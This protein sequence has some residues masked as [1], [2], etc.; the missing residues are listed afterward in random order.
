MTRGALP[1][2]GLYAITDSSLH[3]GAALERAVAL[4]IDGGAAIIQY[5]D[6]T[7]DQDRRHAEATRLLHLCRR[8]G[9]PLIVND[10][11]ELAL[12]IGA[13][14]V[15]VGRE[16]AAPGAT[17]A[18]VGSRLI[19]GVSCYDDP[20]C[21]VQAQDLGADYVAFGA[22][23]PSDTKP[24]AGRA[25][26]AT[27]REARARIHLPIVAIGGITPRNGAALLRAGVDMLAVVRGVFASPDPAVSAREYCK[28]F[29]E[30]AQEVET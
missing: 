18:R 16:D 6:K 14:G 8:R 22:M 7:D 28:L 23:Y 9:V 13:D 20:E 12:R 10:D 21:A 11:V 30:H 3:V 25:D 29:E 2:S 26:I 15:H 1:S 17:R 27:V 5:R 4:A 24:G 19:I